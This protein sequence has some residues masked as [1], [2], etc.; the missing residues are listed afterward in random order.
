MEESW[1]SE[2]GIINPKEFVYGKLNIIDAPC[3]CGKTTFVEHKLWE[4]SY[5]GKMLYLIDTKNALEAFQHRG[6]KRE[7][8]GR[9][10]Y[11]HQWIVAMT[12]ATFAVLC[13]YNADK[14]LWDDEDA[15]IVCDELQSAIKWSKIKNDAHNSGFEMNL[16]QYA[17]NEL[18]RRIKIG[19]RVVAITATPSSLK[20]EF[21]TE[22]TMVPI[23]GKLRQY[24]VKNRF[25]FNNLAT[26]LPH[27]PID[28]RGVI[29]TPHVTQIQEICTQLNNRGIH[30]VGVW[31]L[32]NETHPMSAE[33][34]DVRDN[35]LLHETIPETVQVLVINAA[36]ETGINIKSPVDYFVVNDVN[37]DTQIQAV[38]R[39]RHDIDTVYYRHN[40]K[41]DWSY[42]LSSIFKD[43]WFNRKLY[44]D[45][46]TELCTNLCI[47]DKKGRM[48]KWRKV[49]EIF[50]NS[51]FSV[52]DK[53]EKQGSR[54]SI[55][56]DGSQIV[57]YLHMS[58]THF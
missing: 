19:A 37:L 7:Y 45:D 3:G 53:Q 16:H 42:H 26:L 48:M 57:E 8:N 32:A 21:S 30:A 1:L 6:E 52:I 50:L 39:V 17:L 38:G 18:H 15:L 58:T 9:V 23:H 24:H 46:K 10:Y 4:Q 41:C 31:S 22:Y 43:K 12:Y 13:Y 29:Y 20:K 33:S 35:I 44:R 27:L 54:Y 2:E 25:A 11:R 5:W 56:Q 47:Y 49:K 51:G 55:I 40:H 34:M 28:K 14:S 36:S